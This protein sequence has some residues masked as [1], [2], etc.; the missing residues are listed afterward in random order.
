MEEIEINLD[1][2]A[3]PIAVGV[4]R[5]ALFMGLGLNAVARE[6]V[7]EVALSS[8][9]HQRALAGFPM[10]FIPRD[11]SR[12]IL[13]TYKDEFSTWLVGAAL[14]ELMEHVALTLD[15]LHEAALCALSVRDPAK[16][17]SL[18]GPPEDLH[19]SF[20]ERKG[21]PEKFQALSARFDISTPHERALCSLY[22]A[23]NCLTHGLGVVSGKAADE[24][25]WLNI[26]WVGMVFE[27]VGSESGTVWQFAEM[28]G[29][30]LPEATKVHL[31][32]VERVKPVQV[33]ERIQ[34]SHDELA[35]I[36]YFVGTPVANSLLESFV[37]FMKRLGIQLNAPSS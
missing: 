30:P 27:L 22:R 29:V 20:A 24:T 23:R 32:F 17:R 21:V 11:P 2:I 8:I 25:G 26:G 36:C 10:D 13:A 16:L 4:K 7:T 6:D 34:F 28:V 9:P 14:R 19:R 3:R 18:G 5:A 15:M 31:R 12:E 35:E 33:G 1:R 37:S